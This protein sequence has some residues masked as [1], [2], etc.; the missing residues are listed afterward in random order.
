MDANK[1]EAS[2]INIEKDGETDS[3]H[4]RDRAGDEEKQRREKSRVK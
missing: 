1:G 3:E 2:A 4:Q